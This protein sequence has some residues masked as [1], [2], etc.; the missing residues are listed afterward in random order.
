[1]LARCGK[2]FAV[3]L[4][5]EKE[6]GN[7]FA[8]CRKVLE[9]MKMDKVHSVRAASS[10]EK[11]WKDSRKS[12]SYVRVSS[13][14]QET[15]GFS[16]DSQKRLLNEYAHQKGLEVQETFTD[17]ETAKKAG[18]TG[19]GKML[20]Y[21]RENPECRII[22]VEKTDRLYRNM[23][24]W[25]ILDEIEG[26]E[27]HLVKENA[28]LN[29]ESRSSEKFIHGIKVL[30]AKNFIDNLSEETRKGILE[31]VRQGIWPSYA[32]IGYEN[33]LRP[34]GKKV[35]E[36]DPLRAPIV[37]RLFESYANGDCA[38]SSLVK[39]AKSAGLSARGHGNTFGKAAIHRILRNP[40]YCGDIFWAEK[41][42]AGIHTPLVSREL[43]QAVQDALDGNRRL[44]GRRRK[45]DY[46]FARL[47]VCGHCGGLMTGQL[48]K[49]FVYYHCSGHF[50]KC[51]EPY[52]RQEKLDSS[53]GGI[54]KTLAVDSVV[55]DWV[56]RDLIQR[57]EERSQYRRVELARIHCEYD[58]IKKR[59][60]AMYEDRLYGRVPDWLFFKKSKEYQ[61]QMASFLEEI[62]RFEADSPLS[63]EK[64]ISV[65]ELAQNAASHFSTLSDTEKRKLLQALVLNAVW[66]DG[67]LA[68]SFR[69]PFD[70]L[71]D[72][73]SVWERK[74]VAGLSSNDLFAIW[75]RRRDLNPHALADSGF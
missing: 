38:I 42:Y 27:I 24:D 58:S 72:A 16:I 62:Q 29:A 30:M 74:K 66:K 26:L 35:I 56:K 47:V 32:P 23:K 55:L 70:I 48:H 33:V 22:L 20:S 25:V 75:Y 9:T 36:P 67:T 50:G 2:H 41:T 73:S 45:H 53:F 34:D 28:V 3:L 10:D 21:L 54:L 64:A 63:I 49:R 37:V 17:I 44:N 8:S 51:P 52:V 65:F 39:L 71:A 61:V 6:V 15:G 12:V 7:K 1:M 59:F 18:R 40:I 46:P 57:R 68:V 4:L 43:W 14:E 31:K 60:E 19:F 11:L 5:L 69:Q 13:K